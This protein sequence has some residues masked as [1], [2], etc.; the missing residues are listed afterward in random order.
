MC[1]TYMN[2]QFKF[3]L[4]E[5]CI[6]L[7]SSSKMLMILIENNISASSLG[8]GGGFRKSVSSFRFHFMRFG[9]TDLSHSTDP[10]AQWMPSRRSGTVTVICD[11]NCL[12]VIFFIGS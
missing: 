12:C 11:C 7:T 2:L 9:T 3:F 1:Y 10:T 4:L 8:D 5:Y 6:H